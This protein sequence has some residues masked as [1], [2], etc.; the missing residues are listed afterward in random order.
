MDNLQLTAIDKNES[1]SEKVYRQLKHLILTNQIKSGVPLNERDLADSLAV[2]RTPIRDALKMLEQ[3][4]WI[5]KSGKSKVVNLLTWKSVQDLIEVRRTIELLSYDLAVAK[6]TPE[7]I[8]KLEN[9]CNE[10]IAE[11]A[12]GSQANHYRAMELDMAFHMEFARITENHN[13]I[14]IMTSMS[15]QLLRTSILSVRYGDLS[16][17]RYKDNHV[18][19]LE[20]IRAGEYDRGREKLKQHIAVWE[21]HLQKV[22]YDVRADGDKVLF[23]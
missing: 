17:G 22:P 1:Y 16:I 18:E 11:T 3:D 14:S 13:I 2:S 21:G 5:V 6:I 4:G 23:L 12:D 20:A 10:M 15:E 9:L 8:A 7:D 19:L